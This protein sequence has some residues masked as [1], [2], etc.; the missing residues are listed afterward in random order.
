MKDWPLLIE[1]SQL[2]D[3][4]HDP[5]LL[6]LDTCSAA[7]YADHHI[8]GAVHIAPSEL[9][10]GVKPAVGKLPSIE[11]LNALFTKVGLTPDKHVV[12]YD[13][14][15]GGWAGRL[16]W[17]LDVIGHQN[18]S[19]IDGGL[20]AWLHDGY[21]TE[22]VANL[23][24]PIE[25]N[26]SIDSL[27]IAEIEDFIHLLDNSQ[28]AIWDARSPEEYRGEKVFAQ[29]GGHI[30]GAINLDWLELINR[31][32]QMR[33][34]DTSKLQSRLNELGLTADKTIITHCQTHHRS[35][36]SYLL[37]K[38]LGYPHIKAYHG[39][40]GEWGNSETTPIETGDHPQPSA[41]KP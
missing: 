31:D 11:A 19:Y 8:P 40:W 37:M 22:K 13:D 6:I 7:N 12:V 18:Y 21:A 30:P 9:Q 27:P 32:K 23:P 38:I 17:T 36:L 1:T 10:S 4:L 3:A 15:G 34:K 33:L 16:I 20:H 28:L 29:R 5:N 14:E 24:A 25:Q 2:A 35:G 26:I 39:S 41:Q